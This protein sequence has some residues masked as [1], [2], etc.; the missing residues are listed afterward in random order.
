MKKYYAGYIGI[1]EKSLPRVTEKAYCFTVAGG[2]TC[3]NDTYTYLP[4]SQ[5]IIEKPNEYGNCKFY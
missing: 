1:P 2:Y 3:A 5:C 4:K